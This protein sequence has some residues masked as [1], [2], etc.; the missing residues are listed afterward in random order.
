MRQPR[1][2]QL[3]TWE[4]HV[5]IVLR[6]LVRA[7][8]LLQSSASKAESETNLNR[9][10]YFCLLKANDEM[11]QSTGDA[12]HHPPT[13]EGKNPAD[14]DD[15]CRAMRENKIPDF[16]WGFIDHTARDPRRGARNFYI[17]CKRLGKP[18][19]SGWCFNEN[20]IHHGVLRFITEQHAYAK[21]EKEAAMVGYVQNMD[22]SDVLTEV[23]KTATTASIPPLSGPIGGWNAAGTSRLD[24]QLTRP[25]QL[26]PLLLRHLWIDIR[27]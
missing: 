26:S 18:T 3:K 1:I 17:E 24:H 21:G 23:N 15:L 19:T 4:R 2:S 25:F 7:L 10:L 20:Y 16:Y 14:P 13:P 8:S 27:A 5:S 12:L 22:F 6:V 11:Y 9:E